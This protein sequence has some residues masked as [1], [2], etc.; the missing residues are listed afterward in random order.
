MTITHSHGALHMRRKDEPDFERL[1]REDALELR[2]PPE[3]PKWSLR[4]SILLVVVVNAALWGLIALG[5]AM[6]VRL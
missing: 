6:C 5:L 3:P 2:G 1:M 4:R